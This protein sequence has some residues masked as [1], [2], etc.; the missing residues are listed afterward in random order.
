MNR[1]GS[2]PP[3][4]LKAYIWRSAQNFDVVSGFPGSLPKYTEA[5][6]DLSSISIPAFA[7]ACFTMAWV[8]CRTGLIEVW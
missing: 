7:A 1:W 5:T 4:M 2:G 6:T 3:V 8:F